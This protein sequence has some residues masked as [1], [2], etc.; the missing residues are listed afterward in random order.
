VIVFALTNELV[1][2]LSVSEVGVTNKSSPA[3]AAPHPANAIPRKRN[4]ARKV[5]FIE[6]SPFQHFTIEVGI[7]GTIC[8]FLLGIPQKKE[9][10]AHCCAVSFSLAG[11]TSCAALMSTDHFVFKVY[12]AGD[13]S[14][15]HHHR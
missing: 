9:N 4:G 15:P 8:A 3:V 12:L 10:A 5:F 6:K 7:K 14:Q 2:A 13:I 1:N 11:L